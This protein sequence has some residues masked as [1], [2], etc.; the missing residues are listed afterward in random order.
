MRALWFTVVQGMSGYTRGM[1]QHGSRE[2]QTL[3]GR[4]LTI[5]QAIPCRCLRTLMWWQ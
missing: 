1:G 5:S 3:M 4:L 2:E